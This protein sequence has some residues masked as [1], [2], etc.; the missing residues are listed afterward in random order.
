MQ[1][2]HKAARCPALFVSACVECRPTSTDSQLTHLLVSYAATLEA[3]A[4][5]DQAHG[6]HEHW[7]DVRNRH[8][9]PGTQDIVCGGKV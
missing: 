1:V 9:A 7:K 5:T 6:D 3:D 2:S 4:A 8:P